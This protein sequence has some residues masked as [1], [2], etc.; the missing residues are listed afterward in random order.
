MSYINYYRLNN[1]TNQK[2][3]SRAGRCFGPDFAGEIQKKIKTAKA[4]A[5]LC[6]KMED[7]CFA[8]QFRFVQ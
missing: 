6:C 8:W 1:V 3:L 5:E 2:K 4:C 7:N